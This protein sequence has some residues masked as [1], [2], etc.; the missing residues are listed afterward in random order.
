MDGMDVKVEKPRDYEPD[1]LD[2]KV[3]NQRDFVRDVDLNVIT[4]RCIFSHPE[5]S[6]VVYDT[7]FVSHAVYDVKRLVETLFD[8][9]LMR[10]HLSSSSSS[11]SPESAAASA[12]PSSQPPYELG[13]SRRV[14]HVEHFAGRECSVCQS[15]YLQN[16]F[17]RTLP[18]CKHMFHKRC[19]DPWIKRNSSP[20]C[21]VCRKEIITSTS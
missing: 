3:E 1:G 15:P 5:S 10:V 6:Q 20:T 14:V 9:Y 12:V 8:E 13:R 7:D 17:V 18:V 19:I 2:V 11:S 16:E 4:F 21:P